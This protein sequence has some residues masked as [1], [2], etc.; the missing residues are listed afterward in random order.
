MTKIIN[1]SHL[2]QISLRMES[3]K[4][5]WTGFVFENFSLKLVP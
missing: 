5:N 4:V 3:E 1:G 2:N